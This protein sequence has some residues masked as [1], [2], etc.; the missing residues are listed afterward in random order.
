[1]VVCSYYMPAY[2]VVTL[3]LVTTTHTGIWPSWNRHIIGVGNIP[4]RHNSAR[5]R[6][7]ENRPDAAIKTKTVLL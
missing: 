4:V 3:M 5:K 6:Q 7:N 2:G 1:M